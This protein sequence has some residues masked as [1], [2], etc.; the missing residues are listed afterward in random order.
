MRHFCTE[1]ISDCSNLQYL[2]DFITRNIFKSSAKIRNSEKWIMAH[3]SLIKTLKNRGPRLE[4][5]GTPDSMGKGEEDFPKV[6]TM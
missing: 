6:R 5:C 2:A 4:P 3:K 1:S